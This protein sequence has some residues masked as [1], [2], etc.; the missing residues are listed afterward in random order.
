M[1]N[2]VLI[3]SVHGAKI[4]ISAEEVEY[5]KTLGWAE[6][7]PATLVPTAKLNES[8]SQE[9]AETPILNALPLRRG[10]VRLKAQGE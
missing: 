7:K 4:A 10:R 6:F 5:D 1:A 3:H 2:T 9:V 8:P